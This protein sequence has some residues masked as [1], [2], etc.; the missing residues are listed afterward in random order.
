[1]VGIPKPNINPKIKPVLD[2][3]GSGVGVGSGGKPISTWSWLKPKFGAPKYA[4]LAVSDG[5]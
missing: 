2:L 5:T 4:S 1:M 3:D